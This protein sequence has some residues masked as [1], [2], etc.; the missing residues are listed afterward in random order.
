MDW[1]GRELRADKCGSIPAHV[2]P[3]L[4]RLQVQSSLFVDAV[5][6]FDQW[7]GRAVGRM[8]RLVEIT[9][10]TGCRSLKGME[11]CAAV[12]G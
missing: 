10:R 4:E 6:Y 1:T 12:F 2:A 3:I 5:R 11:R 8:A 7:F 9:A